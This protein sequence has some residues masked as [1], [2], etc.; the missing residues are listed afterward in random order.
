MERPR[1]KVFES[2]LSIKKTRGFKMAMLNI[3][4]LPKHFKEISLMLRDK[5]IDVLALNKTRLDSS[6]S[7]DLIS[8]DG[9][10]LICANRNRNGG[11]VC[12]YARCNINY[13]KRLDLVPNSLEAVS[14][15]IKQA[16][17]QSFIISTIYRPPNSKT[18]DF[19]K[20]ERLVQL[21]DNENKEVYIL[22][23]LNINLLVQNVCTYKKL[24]K[25]MELYQLTQIINDPTRITESTRSLLDVCIYNIT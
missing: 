10:D 18:E 19:L 7:D 22:G 6:I 14:L 24:Q 15:E 17:S 20:I 16:N 13:L 2:G 1:N 11:G 12:I 3:A 4:S 5:K 21:A 8:V 9:Y 23:D 25:I